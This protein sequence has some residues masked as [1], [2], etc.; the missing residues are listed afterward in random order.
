MPRG[1]EIPVFCAHY[2]LIHPKNKKGT[3]FKNPLDMS[4]FTCYTAQIKEGIHDDRAG[5][6]QQRT[7]GAQYD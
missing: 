4:G 5:C 1:N 3:F 6:N 2:P 7:D